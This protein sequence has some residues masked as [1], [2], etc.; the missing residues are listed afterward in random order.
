[1]TQVWDSGLS[2]QG[3][4]IQ[5][6]DD[7]LESSNAEFIGRYSLSSSWNYESV[8]QDSTPPSGN[9]HG[10]SCAGISAGAMNNSYCGVGV[11]YKATVSGIRF[12]GVSNTTASVADALTG[13]ASAINISSNSWG[14]VSSLGDYY[15][16]LASTFDAL[17]SL[18]DRDVPVLF[19][20][21][22]DHLSAGS[23]ARQEMTSGP[24][25]IVV[26]AV[27]DRNVK[28]AYS[29]ECPAVFVSAPSS[30]PYYRDTTHLGITAPGLGGSCSTTF[31][32]TSAATPTVSGL[33][34]LIKEL[35]T[36]FSMRDIQYVLAKSS[37][38]VDPTDSSWVTNAAGFSHSDKYGFGRI[39]AGK[40]T[41]LAKTFQRVV[42]SSWMPV[43]I[44]SP[45]IAIPDGSI[46][47]VTSTINVNVP[48]GS[49]VEHI[50]AYLAIN[51]ASPNQLTVTLKSPS[52]TVSTLN[53][54][55]LTAPA[56]TVVTSG[57]LYACTYPSY[58]YLSPR[59]LTSVCSVASP[60]WQYTSLPTRI[61]WGSYV[62][63]YYSC[64]LSSL[65]STTRSNRFVIIATDEPNVVCA[66]HVNMID[67]A[68]SKGYA[69]VVFY[70]FEP[71]LNWSTTTT[72]ASIPSLWIPIW[73]TNAWSLMTSMT[74]MTRLSTGYRPSSTLSS[75]SYF[76]TWKAFGENPNGNWT[77]SVRDG[78]AGTTGTLSSWGLEMRYITLPPVS[79][80]IQSPTSAPPPMAAPV[81]PPT[82]PPVFPPAASPAQSPTTIPVS[83]PTLSPVAAPRASPVA[84]P[85][86]PPFGA[87]KPAPIS[88]PVFA[89]SVQ[90][91]SNP[92]MEPIS[93]PIASLASPPSAPPTQVG[94]LRPPTQPPAAP[95]PV[96]PP[97]EPPTLAT[98]IS[99]PFKPPVASPVEPPTAEA[100]AAAP[101]VNVTEITG[102][103]PD[104][105][106]VDLPAYPPTAGGT[107]DPETSNISG[108]LGGGAVFA[109][110]AGVLVGGVLIAV[111]AHQVLVKKFKLLTFKRRT[112]TPGLTVDISALR[113]RAEN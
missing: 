76:G 70:S 98:P 5:F 54:P 81:G 100:P 63:V 36:D 51:H 22:N 78:T 95:P 31:G 73:Q 7:G 69:G 85:V 34:A 2:G 30:D 32:G 110:I 58:V 56:Y 108:S 105:A 44:V 19:A 89:P 20:S 57:T 27:N 6:V 11:A 99:P 77:L 75:Y 37:D 87:P 94:P 28:S 18:A 92:V 86:A 90:P 53:R 97:Q 14:Y 82:R 88:P 12:I 26:G 68:A 50:G 29:S 79:A 104:A 107:A 13:H 8:R 71:Y 48:S 41:S 15:P 84:S 46:A 33:L 60:Y 72:T 74:A 66:N 42:T 49:A 3:V 80:P 9:S 62:T 23:C 16:E 112:A 45:N 10:T 24:D 102:A 47:S 59:I 55:F 67:T 91:V 64:D 38:K 109:I 39:N 40:A 113:G 43:T 61:T 25:T 106:P 83:A 35:R 96:E 101:L 21:G 17:T 52:G 111:I 65:A 103:S 1:V 4:H 93:P